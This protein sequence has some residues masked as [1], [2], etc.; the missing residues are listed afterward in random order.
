MK[1][2]RKGECSA[3]NRVQKSGPVFILSSFM[4]IHAVSF[5]LSFAFILSSL[6]L[7]VINHEPAAL[8][9][10]KA[11]LRT[12]GEVFIVVDTWNEA[13]AR[14]CTSEN[15]F[16]NQ[17][18]SGGPADSLNVAYR[19]LTENFCDPY[20]LDTRLTY[21]F[22]LAD[23]AVAR[24]VLVQKTYN[25]GRGTLKE[26]EPSWFEVQIPARNNA[27]LIRQLDIETREVSYIASLGL[28][29]KTQ[30][31]AKR[32]LALVKSMNE[33]EPAAIK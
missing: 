18:H 2:T 9:E 15:L 26:G 19:N 10:L 30:A 13:S 29:F 33:P 8:T 24:A 21:S 28:I 7:P 5:L 4:V 23:L 17:L 16:T 27:A 20:V 25:Y 11:L 3:M 14:N 12:E 32:A 22:R 1:L 6:I 31:G